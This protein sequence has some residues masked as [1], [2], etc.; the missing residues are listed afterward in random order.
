[1]A[2]PDTDRSFERVGDRDSREVEPVEQ[3]PGFARSGVAGSG[4]SDWCAGIGWRARRAGQPDGPA[5]VAAA[6]LRTGM[7][8]D[9]EHPGRTLKRNQ[10]LEV[11]GGRIGPSAATNRP[12][13]SA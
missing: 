8:C 12:E 6:G 13:R 11:T 5:A 2:R 3:L 7:T 4:A 10:P 1:M 9:V